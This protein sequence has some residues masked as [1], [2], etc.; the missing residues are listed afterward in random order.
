MDKR[1]FSLL[2]T[3]CN[4]VMATAT[5][6]SE[7]CTMISARDARLARTIF[8]SDAHFREVT[9]VIEKLQDVCLTFFKIC[10][11]GPFAE[12]WKRE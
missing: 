4:D 8:H 9:E 3:L 7:I 5:R 1:S 10:S 6:T 2:G 11:S 12:S